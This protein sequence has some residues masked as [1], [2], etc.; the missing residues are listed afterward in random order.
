MF[1]IYY[2]IIILLDIL[3]GDIY[4]VTELQYFVSNYTNIDVSKMKKPEILKVIELKNI[5]EGK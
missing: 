2:L 1:W 3:F 5:E 4:N